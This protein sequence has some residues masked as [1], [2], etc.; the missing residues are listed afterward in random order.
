M[1]MDAH[2][3][4]RVSGSG[5]SDVHNYSGMKV[6]EMDAE[7]HHLFS[8]VNLTSIF[9]RL[10]RNL[11]KLPVEPSSITLVPDV[12]HTLGVRVCAPNS[13]S[14]ADMCII[15][16]PQRALSGI[17]LTFDVI[18]QR[19]FPCKN[20]L[21]VIEFNC[22]LMSS[23]RV[24][25]T[26]AS[27]VP[28]AGANRMLVPLVPVLTSRSFS[29]PGI[30]VSLLPVWGHT[31]SAIE[32]AVACSARVVI[33]PPEYNGISLCSSPTTVTV[34]V[35]HDP[36]GV[37]RLTAATR[38]GDIRA[39]TIALQDGCSIEEGALDWMLKSN[40]PC[41]PLFLAACHGR[42]DVVSF[43]LGVGADPMARG[44]LSAHA[45]FEAAARNFASVVTV[46]LADVR[47]DLNA[48]GSKVSLSHCINVLVPAISS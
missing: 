31:L 8:A 1:K 38:T 25:A 26:L 43:L 23:I 45:F 28:S 21:E 19:T 47:V 14:H 13:P 24:I 48:P 39:M 18:P 10:T 15:N 42:A 16:M 9:E 33:L 12:G 4:L 20:Q 40:G 5:D 7:V 2:N 11:S 3:T 17:P 22:S 46:L 6:T 29:R 27:N 41:R 32:F 30:T 37:G 35:N 36:V 34:G 44:L